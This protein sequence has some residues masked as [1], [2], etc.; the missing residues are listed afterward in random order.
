MDNHNKLPSQRL[1]KIKLGQLSLLEQIIQQ[2]VNLKQV[3]TPPEQIRSENKDVKAQLAGLQK[4]VNDNHKATN[5]VM[6]TTLPV[7]R[8]S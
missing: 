7:T 1:A 6:I 2:G 3:L 8:R 4:T 5:T